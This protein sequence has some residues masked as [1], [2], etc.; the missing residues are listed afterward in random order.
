MNPALLAFIFDLAMRA[1]DSVSKAQ[2]G[3][4]TD[5]QMDQLRAAT[6]AALDRFNEATKDEK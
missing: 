2:G 4:L 5:Q 6:Q 1:I 3:K